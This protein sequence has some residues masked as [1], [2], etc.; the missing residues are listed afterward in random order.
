MTTLNDTNV[1]GTDDDAE[2]GA[3]YRWQVADLVD[4]GDHN[5]WDTIVDQLISALDA[6]AFE[7][8]DVK[9]RLIAGETVAVDPWGDG[10]AAAIDDVAWW[11]EQDADDDWTALASFVHSLSET[12]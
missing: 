10:S 4:V 5:G 2:Y 8:R 3:G 1:V 6:R 9:R 7:L 11:I 12:G